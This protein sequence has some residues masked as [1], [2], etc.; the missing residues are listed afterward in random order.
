M[1]GYV[2]EP[3]GCASLGLGHIATIRLEISADLCNQLTSAATSGATLIYCPMGLCP[4]D[5]TTPG[6][7]SIAA[8]GQCPSGTYVGDVLLHTGGMYIQQ[9]II[10][11]RDKSKER[12]NK[13]QNIRSTKRS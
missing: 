13:R 5:G 1:R 10:K 11:H 8:L 12:V 6:G 7:I 2:I 3:E 4:Y 9:F